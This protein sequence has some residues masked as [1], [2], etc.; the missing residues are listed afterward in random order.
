MDRAKGS[1]TF[2]RNKLYCR[3]GL[4]SSLNVGFIQNTKPDRFYPEASGL[5]GLIFMM[6]TSRRHTGV[7]L[8]DYAFSKFT[9]P[10]FIIN[11]SQLR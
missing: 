1:F 2:R 7:H 5:S 3:A 6:V 9:N 11:N 10:Q 4:Q 8:Y